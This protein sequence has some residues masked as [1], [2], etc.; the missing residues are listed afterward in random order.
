MEWRMSPELSTDDAIGPGQNG[1]PELNDDLEF[2]YAL[3][4]EKVMAGFLGVTDRTLQ[5]WRRTGG[6]P[7][8][9]RVSSRCVRYRRIDG[10]GF[11]E[12]RLRSSTSDPGNGAAG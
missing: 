12:D 1:G 9:V 5:K 8:F 11:S 3:I 7:P 4:V 2:W 6:G 10:R